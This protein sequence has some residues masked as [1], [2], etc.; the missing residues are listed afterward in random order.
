MNEV[1]APGDRTIL[2]VG[3]RK[4]IEPKLKALGFKEIRL[5]DPDG[6]ILQSVK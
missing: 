6:K 5:V 2:V 3:D 4:L 1:V